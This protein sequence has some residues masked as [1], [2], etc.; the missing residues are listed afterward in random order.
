MF[1]TRERNAAAGPRINIRKAK[2]EG[3]SV[4]ERVAEQRE[5]GRASEGRRESERRERRRV[6]ERELGSSKGISSEIGVALVG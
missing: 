1:S 2:E 6:V 3:K 4:L 5:E